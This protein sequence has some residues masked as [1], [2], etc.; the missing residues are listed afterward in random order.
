MEME[1]ERL[2]KWA[3]LLLDT[4][5]GNNLI[6]FKDTKTSTVELLFPDFATILD[7]SEKSAR[8]EI[9][10]PKIDEEA[11][12]KALSKEEYLAKY[13]SK[14]K[15]NNIALAYNVDGKPYT[16]LK[17]VK[18]RADSAME[19]AGVN[20]AY[21]AFGFIEWTEKD[22]KE[23]LLHAPILLAPVS[24]EKESA[25][26]PYFLNI[27]ADITINPTFAY[28][29]Q[30]EY[31]IVI[32]AYDEEA[33]VEEY[34]DKVLKLVEGLGWS[35]QTE[36]KV[37]L[38]SF[39][40]IN[41]YKDLK[42]NAA[43]IL[44]NPNIRALLNLPALKEEDAPDAP[45][46]LHNVVD[47][48]SSQN[49]AILMAQSGKSFVL[50]GP[51]GTGKSQSIT[52]MIAECLAKGKKVLF[53]S[54][55]RAALNVV[56]DKLKKLGLE[57]FCLALHSY[58][59]NKKEVI[60]ELCRTLKLPKSAVSGRAK[61]EIEAREKA[62]AELDAYAE[63]LHR[64]RPLVEKSI[65]DLYEAAAAERS[66]PTLDF[67]I[68]D[69]QKK[70]EEYLRKA[71]TYL[72]RYVEY[73]DSIG[74]DYR[75][76]IWYGYVDPDGSYENKIRVREDFRRVTE[77]AERLKE[78][79]D[80]LV[81]ERSVLLR[82]FREA[83]LCHT[84]FTLAADSPFLTPALL[85]KKT[86]KKALP[87][88]KKM[89]E[90]ADEILARRK[91]LDENYTSEIYD[92]PGA[93][94]HADLS[95]K[96]GSGLKRLFS[97]DYKA[98]IQDLAACRKD[99]KKPDYKT[100]LHTTAVLAKH[101]DFCD[102]FLA[103]ESRVKTLLSEEGYTGVTTNFGRLLKDLD[104]LQILL[105]SGLELG[106]L[107]KMDKETFFSLKDT[108]YDYKEDL[109]AALKDSH[110][111]SL[112][113][114][115]DA[116][117]YDIEEAALALII[118][119][120]RNC[121]DN[122]EELDN[123][124]VFRTLI[125][126]I[127]KEDLLSYLNFALDKEVPADKLISAHRKAFFAQ[128][129]DVLLRS[130]PILSSLTRIPHDQAVAEFRKKDLLTFEINKALIKAK[131]SAERPSLDLIAQGSAVSIL[132]REG[133]KKRRQKSIRALLSE[134]RELAQTLKPCFLMSPLSVSTFLGAGF[135]FDVVIFDEASQIF[136]QDAVCSIYRGKQLIVVGDS[137]QMPPS[138]FFTSN[139]LAEEEEAEE[140]DVADFESILDLCATVFPQL[141]LKWH[142]RSRFEQLISFS[143]KH[144]YENDLVTFPSSLED[145]PG[146]GVDY[147]YVDGV[148]DRR[149]RTNR[150]EAEKMVDLVFEHIEKYPERSLGVVAFSISQQNLIDRLI[151]ERRQKDP[152]KE[153]FFKSDRE[154][155]F[156]VKNLETVQGD[157]R[158]TILFSVAYGKGT[159][160]KL[161]LNFGPINKMGG[162]RRLNVAITRAKC[163]IV[164]LTSMHGYDIDP[165]RTASRGARLLGAYLD[166]AEK[167]A[168]VLELGERAAE[169]SANF[170]K[171]VKEFLIANGYEAEAKV[172]FSAFKV[173]LAVKAPGS[174]RFILAIEFDGENYHAIKDTRDR[175]RLR[176]GVL[177]RMGWHFYRLWSTE[178]VRNNKTEKERLLAAVKQAAESAGEAPVLPKEEPAAPSFEETAIEERF[179]FPT[180]TLVSEFQAMKKCR[181]D[182]AG[183]VKTIVETESPVQEEWLLKRI[184]FLFGKD[185]VTSAVRSDYLMKMSYP[186]RYGMERK[187]EFLYL[188]GKETPLLRVPAEDATVIRDVKQIALE[189]LASGIRAV[190]EKNVSVD[191]L[192]LYRFLSQLLGFGRLSDGITKRLDDALALLAN[193]IET[194][195]SVL[196]LK[197]KD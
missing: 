69:I 139:T 187:G 177:E 98:I 129:I 107:K 175:D 58:R 116:E 84:L 14:L 21:V 72:E 81:K 3:E 123:W 74:Y 85:D 172:G 19:E 5:K 122:I 1:N 183:V 152:S 4:G 115:F 36:C 143:N 44:E 117:E 28:K 71:D 160:G 130:S 68:A 173:D 42:E 171:D 12:G 59:A 184:C 83:H 33:P 154:E 157:E 158:D 96:Y 27:A 128:W 179:E 25:T 97:S 195:G 10:D 92:K 51:P 35:V 22:D 80:R 164:L 103:D 145:A 7:R 56:Y 87:Y 193:E 34:Y 111:A 196:S 120:L 100:A 20:I 65:Y 188:A 45:A 191:K 9:L 169:K 186:E 137:K 121:N 38:F 49:Q 50:Q 189:E 138:N 168:S 55:K 40:K 148:F 194:D 112:A 60:D 89:A 99:G 127:R 53:V 13:E 6:N 78:V 93:K 102:D 159:D 167:G 16:A 114:R 41:M 62:K 156:F 95:F 163:N 17:N 30:S 180:Y 147:V 135:T 64:L 37:G 18:K 47:A 94:Y 108:F 153:E 174:D 190:L 23:H 31:G 141:R 151:T 161:L 166:Y 39:M 140:D 91:V 48:D 67:A 63:E 149:T 124:L 70:G 73:I 46:E 125:E 118:P 185:K 15:K 146:V 131:L 110:E 192:A 29:L 170:E 57:E 113:A 2:N 144:F 11:G 176:Q 133:E 136:P 197:D 150:A 79:A 32:P 82:N 106:D 162:E 126:D 134:I 52:N 132:L 77:S 155:P 90:A 8:F 75:N 54:E 105:D 119:K 178:W 182:V 142:Y 109:A 76:N 165:K 104:D 88:L 43:T 24:I 26:T 61:G 86:L 181:G 101:A 66:A